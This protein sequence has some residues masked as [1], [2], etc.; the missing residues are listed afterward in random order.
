MCS[1]PSDVIA[2]LRGVIVWHYSQGSALMRKWLYERS[3]ILCVCSILLYGLICYTV[4]YVGV[5]VT[6][7]LGPIILVSGFLAYCLHQ[8]SK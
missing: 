1:T 2:D 7:V 8:P 3:L 4:S 6:Y 5:Y